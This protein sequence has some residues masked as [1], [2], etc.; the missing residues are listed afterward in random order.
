[1]FADRQPMIEL[2]FRHFVKQRWIELRREV[3]SQEIA[4]SVEE[5]ARQ[6]YQAS[7]ENL[8]LGISDSRTE[9]EQLWR[10]LSRDQKPASD[11]L[12]A[13]GRQS[14][15]FRRSYPWWSTVFFAFQC[16]TMKP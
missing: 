7:G 16:S 11:W 1:M 9:I 15:V 8:T 13:S 6:K 12:Q 10:N 4:S 14:V 2:L 3:L 5:L